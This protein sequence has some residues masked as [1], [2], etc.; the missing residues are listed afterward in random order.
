MNCKRCGTLI[1]DGDQ[2]CKGCGAL[3][4]EMG[5]NQTIPEIQKPDM[6]A[7]SNQNEWP[8]LTQPVGQTPI[9]NNMQHVAA[10]QPIWQPVQNNAQQSNFEQPVSQ[11]PF[12]NN[13]QHVDARQPVNNGYNQNNKKANK[14][15]PIIIGIVAVVVFGA[16]CIFAGKTLFSSKG[17]EDKDGEVVAQTSN[18]YKVTF[19]NFTFDVPDDLV[20]ELAT[21]S[22]LVGDQAGTWA[23]YIEVAEGNYTQFLSKKS[24]LQSVYQKAGY[25]SSAAN[26]RKVNGTSYVTLELLSSGQKSIIAFTKANSKYVF[27]ITAYNLANSYDYSILDT[28]S[29]ILASA[30]YNEGTT[31]ITTFTKPDIK[32]VSELAQ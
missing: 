27:G 28:M 16:I 29:K 2:F 26:E 12:Q 9:E 6:M 21:D 25:T 5:E 13:T 19:N 22:L 11:M 8:N 4:S 31:N 18:T 1:T 17:A 14:L 30:K 32:M 23:A 7:S 10:E 15:I 24:Q 3:V 20:Y